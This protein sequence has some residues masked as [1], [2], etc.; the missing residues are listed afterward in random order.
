MKPASIYTL[1][2][3]LA[4]IAEAEQMYS[5]RVQ[6][7][8]EKAPTIEALAEALASINKPKECKRDESNGIRVSDT[9]LSFPSAANDIYTFVIAQ[10]AVVVRSSSTALHL[11]VGDRLFSFGE[12]YIQLTPSVF[13]RL[14]EYFTD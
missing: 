12:G 4:E 6:E 3:V 14:T 5:E 9:S 2:H 11:Y 7:E 10:I 1:L 8:I 13:K